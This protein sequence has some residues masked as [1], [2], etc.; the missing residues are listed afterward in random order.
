M[1]ALWD[2]I[3]SSF[4]SW[5]QSIVPVGPQ[6]P[7]GISPT[8]VVV[9]SQTASY[10]FV[11]ADNGTVVTSESAVA[12]NWTL[13]LNMPVGFNVIVI[14]NGVGQVT[15]VPGAGVTLNKRARMGKTA[16]QFAEVALL[17]TASNVY[18][19]AGDAI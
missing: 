15:F 2:A 14:Q 5:V 3:E 6:G 7:A 11:V 19:L 8:S 18:K 10:T 17:V 13:P 4:S 16:A 9:T 12:V 1:S